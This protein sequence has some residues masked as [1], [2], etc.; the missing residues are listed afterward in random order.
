M[1]SRLRKVTLTAHVVFS[2]GWLGAIVPYLALAVAGLTS[3]DAQMARAAYLSMEVIGWFVIVPFC[4]AAL[5]S[6]LVQSLGTQWGLFRHWWVLMKFLLTIVAAVILLRHMQ[7]VSRVSRMAKETMLSSADFRPELIHAA[8]GLLVVLVATMLSVFKPW[9][10]TSYGVKK[11][12]Q[13]DFSS[14]PSD[15]A[16]VAREPVLAIK[17]IGWARII[18]IHAV[19]LA[20]L[21]VLILHLT[22]GGPHH[23]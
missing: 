18:G 20:S 6:G 13:A 17:R 9:G 11:M 21:L 7:D 1:N 3:H 12:S 8:G 2:V 23:H 10:M 15:A 4:L 22:G 19:G 5:L 14:R 16:V